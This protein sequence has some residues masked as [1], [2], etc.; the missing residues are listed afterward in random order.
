MVVVDYSWALASIG[1]LV[2]IALLL[3]SKPLVTFKNPQNNNVAKGIGLFFILYIFNSIFSFW[4]WDTFHTWGDFIAAKKY[5][6]G[7]DALLYYEPVYVWLGKFANYNYFLWRSLVWAPACLLIYFTGRR[8]NILNRNLLVSMALF[9]VFLYST[10]NL[11]GLAML[12]FGLVLFVDDNSHSKFWGLVLIVASYFFHRTMF[13]TIVFAGLALF[14][15]NRASIVGLLITYPFAVVVST[16]VIGN[17]LSGDLTITAGGG[18]ENGNRI[19][20]YASQERAV[21]TAYGVI[22]QVITCLPQYLALAYV[23]KRIV[24]DKILEGDKQQKVWTYL[25]SF[26]F[27]CIY[28]ASCFYFTETSMWI[29]ERFKYMGMIPLTFVL[30]KVW[31][32]EPRS[33]IWVKSMIILQLLSLSY[34]WFMQYYHWTSGVS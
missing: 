34:R 7:S 20:N 15:Q 25:M 19:D 26:S 30:A 2:C 1:L 32:V 8:L 21:L 4:E 24:F 5:G 17:I 9:L 12:L 33:N 13:I 18:G 28:I 29:F 23:I 10:R 11:L 31:S 22:R 6:Y 3:I 14:K 27:V 16:L